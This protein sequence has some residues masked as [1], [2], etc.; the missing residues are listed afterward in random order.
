[1]QCKSEREMVRKI[2]YNKILENQLE[3]IVQNNDD[4]LLSFCK[5]KMPKYGAVTGF[6]IRWLNYEDYR[7]DI[8]KICVKFSQLMI[9]NDNG[10]IIAL[11]HA[12]EIY[13]L[14]INPYTGFPLS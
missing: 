11:S 8:E 5:D 4:I 3:I 12:H 14:Q 10:R 2:K 7:K 6:G 13:E 1:M 9:I